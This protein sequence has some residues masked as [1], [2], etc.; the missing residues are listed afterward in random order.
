MAAATCSQLAWMQ[1]DSCSG[2][3]HYE[4]I[5][6]LCLYKGVSGIA[7]HYQRSSCGSPLTLSKQQQA[8][9]LAQQA[10]LTPLHIK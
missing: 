3:S 2:G 7:P 5:T 8:Q 6:L 4:A 9:P 10:A 1:A